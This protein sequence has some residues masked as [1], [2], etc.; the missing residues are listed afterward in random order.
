MKGQRVLVTGGTR[1]IGFELVRA[2]SR[3]GAEVAFCGRSDQGPDFQ[4]EGGSKPMYFKADLA[5]AEGVEELANRV[6]EEFGRPTIL[7]N[8]AGVQ[9]NHDWTETAPSDRW[10]WA[11]AEVDVNLLAPLGLTAL[12]L[13]DLMA[14]PQAAIVNITSILAGA[15]KRSAPVYSAT[16][17]ALRSFTMGLRYQLEDSP[18]VRLVE[19]IPPWWIPP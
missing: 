4:L 7:V 11:R 18:H 10:G 8:N 2:F 13:E 17:A 14:A 9:F 3:A 15:P 5:S 19:V 12:L 1:G 6:R 16:K